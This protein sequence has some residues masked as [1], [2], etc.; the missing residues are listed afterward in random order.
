MSPLDTFLTSSPVEGGVKWLSNQGLNILFICFGAWL[1]YH[2]VNFVV[3]HLMQ[4]LIRKTR[5]NQMTDLDL[6][7]RQDTVTSLVSTLIRIIIL[8][9]AA[10][11]V[12]KQLFPHI[13]Y[14]PIFAS[15]GIIGVAVG[16]G[17]Q[18]LIKDFLS[19]VFIITENQYRVGDVVDLEN[20]AT[21][22]V[23]RIGI[24]STVLRDGDGNVHY[25]P[26]GNVGHVI[27]KTMGFSKVNFTLSVDADTDVDLLAKIIND[28]GAKLAEDP[29]WKA[30][31]TE[32]P[33]FMNV[34]SFSQ[35]GMD[36]TIVGVTQP[37]EQWSVTGELRR[38][39]L[40]ELVKH[41]IQLAAA[42]PW[43]VPA[44]KK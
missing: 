2:F 16:F 42:S 7:K 40:K 21:G 1:L 34:G 20:G 26:N 19:G 4:R 32:A 39:L 10:M 5:Y 37:S 15:A 43:S 11:M 22:S 14:A 27:N 17:A 24:R 38:R 18:S 33:R 8:A 12:V 31:I 9:T 23:E 13:N 35:L 44:K 41:K 28:T 6:K 36:I 3:E 29:K 30:K 25:V